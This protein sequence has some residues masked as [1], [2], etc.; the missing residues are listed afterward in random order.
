MCPVS[1]TKISAVTVVA[2]SYDLVCP[3]CGR[4]LEVSRISRNFAMLAGLVAGYAAWY[5]ST[6]TASAHQA[7]GWVFPILFSILAFGVVTPLVLM[8]TAD[9]SLKAELP[10]TEPAVL[11]D[12][13][14]APHGGHGGGHH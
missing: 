2:H 9:L 14:H 13:G 5:L 12:A 4:H 8:L 7:L 10:P 6:Q 1:L 11:A 3:E